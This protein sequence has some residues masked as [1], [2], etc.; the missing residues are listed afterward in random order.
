MRPAILEETR[1]AAF[2]QNEWEHSSAEVNGWEP[3]EDHGEGQG[4]G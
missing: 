2:V 3:N 1:H 4:E